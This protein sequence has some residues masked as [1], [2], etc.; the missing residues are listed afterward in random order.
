MYSLEF[1]S[2]VT[3][4]RESHEMS[5]WIYPF[6]S[7]VF[8]LLRPT[9]TENRDSRNYASLR[10]CFP[11]RG[12]VSTRGFIF[13]YLFFF[14]L[15]L[16]NRSI[17]NPPFVDFVLVQPSAQLLSTSETTKSSPFNVF[18]SSQGSPVERNSLIENTRRYLDSRAHDA[19]WINLRKN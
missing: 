14:S 16:P 6:A 15:C 13:L 12:P 7:F 5:A 11:S 8:V 17:P 18:W 3:L 4:L 2:V 10:H 19:Q 9:R 1:F